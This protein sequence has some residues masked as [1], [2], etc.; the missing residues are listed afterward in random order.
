MLYQ[1]SHLKRSTTTRS[2]HEVT[3][4]TKG[5]L[6]QAYFVAFVAFVSS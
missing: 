3:N 6:D 5:L 1:G 4:S 2:Y